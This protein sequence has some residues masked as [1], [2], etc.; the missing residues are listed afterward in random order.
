MLQES[1]L[2]VLEDQKHH[3]LRVKQTSKR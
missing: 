2:L 3:F 1:K